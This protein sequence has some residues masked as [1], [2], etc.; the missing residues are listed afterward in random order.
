MTDGTPGDDA[1][2]EIQDLFNQWDIA[3]RSACFN[4]AHGRHRYQAEVVRL[5]GALRQI[6][7]TEFWKGVEMQ[8]IAREALAEVGHNNP[9][10]LCRHS[11]N[12]C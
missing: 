10:A 7:N 8:Q 5:R 1:R 2:R 6:I 12:P 3:F 9:E 4:E 11:K